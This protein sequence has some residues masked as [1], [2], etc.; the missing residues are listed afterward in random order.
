MGTSPFSHSH[1]F[2]NIFSQSVAYI[3]ILLMVS[4]DEPKF[5]N[6]DQ[7]QGSDFFLFYLILSG[8]YLRNLFLLQ[9][10]EDRFF[11]YVHV[12]DSSQISFYLWCEV[13]IKSHFFI[14]IMSHILTIC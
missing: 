13:G 14:H 3:S 2:M 8:S 7:V 1:A 9:G 6:F 10:W 4:F 11:F 12:C 5:F